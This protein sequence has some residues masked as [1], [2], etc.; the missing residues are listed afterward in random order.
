MKTCIKKRRGQ[1]I[2]L[3][4]SS[5]ILVLMAISVVSCDNDEPE[6]NDNNNP[7]VGI[8]S[9]DKLAGKWTLVQDEV[10]Y[11]KINASKKD[12][13]ITY[14][15]NTSPKYHFYKVS[16]SEDDIILIEEVSVTGSLVGSPKTFHLEGNDLMT[17]D[18]IVAGT[19]THYN[20]AHSWDNL[21][22]EWNKE[23]SPVT[24][25]A[26]VISTYML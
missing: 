24:F 7:E 12:E 8:V 4:L 17:M 21:R 18:D 14:S 2:S 23:Y 9:A 16:V 6:N 15:G 25:D 19:I 22:I 20:K 10:L 11:S 26:P 3:L 1:Y 13:V 5:F